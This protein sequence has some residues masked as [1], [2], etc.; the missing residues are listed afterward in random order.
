MDCSCLPL[1]S[2][3]VACAAGTCKG[4]LQPQLLLQLYT[5][6]DMLLHSCLCFER[7]FRMSGSSRVSLCYQQVQSTC[8]AAPVQPRADLQSRCGVWVWSCICSCPSCCAYRVCR[9]T[10]TGCSVYL[11]HVSRW[12]GVWSLKSEPDWSSADSARWC[13]APVAWASCVLLAG[14]PASV[15]RAWLWVLLL[16]QQ[17]LSGLS[18][19]ASVREQS[20]HAAC[21]W[22][23]H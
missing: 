4:C 22:T 17:T 13:Y 9:T 18:R 15:P 16:R 1:S 10:L 5:A 11:L 6:I 3:P 20:R 2:Q 8:A 7:M 14:L 12:V 21:S 19:G 23:R